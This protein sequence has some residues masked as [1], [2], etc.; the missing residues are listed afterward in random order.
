MKNAAAVK[1]RSGRA[2]VLYDGQCL[3]C[4][5]SIQILERLDWL[6]RFDF[7]NLR[8]PGR[9]PV[10]EPPLCP[11]RLLQEMHVLRPGLDR[12]YHGYAALRWIAW[13]LPL[14]WA[15]APWLSVPGIP[16]IG[17]RL[18]LWIARHRFQL[19]PCRG[20]I[21]TLNSSLSPTDRF[22]KT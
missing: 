12:A 20:Q 4:V 19:V 18:Y 16:A 7:V 6:G 13:R 5:R 11:D 21:C 2:M 10:T 22:R 15:V 3:F 14:L 1:A 9:L 17:Q 8:D